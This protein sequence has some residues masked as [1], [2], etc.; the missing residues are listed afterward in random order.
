MNE[1]EQIPLSALLPQQPPFV[2]IDAL[3]EVGER[4]TATRLTVRPDNIF[5][6]HGRLSAYGVLENIAQTCAA[7]IGYANYVRH[8]DV[9]IGY[10]GAVRD[11]RF[12]RLPR[13]GEQ[14]VTRIEVQEEIMG[15]TLVDATV[16]VGGEVLAATQM[17]IAL[18][19]TDSA[20][21]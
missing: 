6:E 10:I 18:R 2:M 21:A 15:L 16:T 13:E 19:E 12:N 8:L 1:F 3:T 9:G 4:S 7:R 5:V 20:T 17:K 11:C 14:L